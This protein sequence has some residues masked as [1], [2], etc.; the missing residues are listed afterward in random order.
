MKRLWIDLVQIFGWKFD[1]PADV[2]A[3]A[4]RCVIVVAPHTSAIDYF[5]GAAC[6]W[7]MGV[8]TR[9]FIKKE[10]FNWLTTP[11][12]KHFGGIAVDRGN[13]HNGLVEQAVEQFASCE[14]LSLVITPEGT[15]RFVK[16]WKRGFYDIA[17]KS[18]VPIVLAHIDYATKHMGIGLV[19][20]PS[21]EYEKDIVTIMDYYKNITPK[22]PEGWN[23][24]ANL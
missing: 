3:K 6:L 9:I 11:I 15:R 14:K 4:Q 13:R 22:H 1:L 10:Y 23:P 18:Q 7:K 2:M 24:Q 12:I 20:Q 16:R 19:L 21:G 17:V 5:V 8:N